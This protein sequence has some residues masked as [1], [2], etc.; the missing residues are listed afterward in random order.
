MKT[1]IAGGDPNWGRVLCAVGNA[2][3]ALRSRRASASDFGD[4]EVVRKRRPRARLRRG[5][6]RAPSCNRPRYAIT[7]DLGGGKAPRPASWRATCRHE[8]V[9][10]NADY[11]VA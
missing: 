7:I 1:A 10:I 4:V 2:G 6:R 9:S 8:Y 11:R 3:V 5:P